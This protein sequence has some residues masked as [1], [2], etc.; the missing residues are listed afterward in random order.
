[1]KPRIVFLV[2]LFLSLFSPVY[3][4]VA[5]SDED[6]FA[7]HEET[8]RQKLNSSI[9][10]EIGLSCFD[11]HS[12]LRGI[13][14]FPHPEKLK[15]VSC[16]TC[17]SEIIK[18]WSKSIHGRAKS[19]GLGVVKCSDCHGDHDV[20]PKGDPQSL[21][22]PL[23]LPKTCE[24]CHLE[25][26]KTPRGSDFIRQYEG[27][28]HFR[29][30]EKAG[31][32]LSAN[33]SH[34]HGSHDILPTEDPDS[35]TSRR[36][37]IRTCGQCHVGIE[38]DY[39]EGVHGKDY[40]KGIK[41]VPVCTDCHQE[42]NILSP[43]DSRSS[44]YATKVAGVCSRCHDDQAIARQYGLLTGRYR[45][46]A[47]SY[48]G[49]ASRFGD[50]RVANCASCHGY[51]DIRPSSDPKSSIHPANIPQ[52]CGRCHPGASRR[53]AEGKVHLLPEQVET[54]KY[55]ISY[56]IKKI[57]IILIATIIS[58]FILFIAADLGRRL[59]RR[60]SHG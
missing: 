24:R 2:A 38:R 39:L 44:V 46:Y 59:W 7:C 3:P 21:V 14:E 8:F 17:H 29:A 50:I 56:I 5:Q 48:H 18:D 57:Y 27:S 33:C 34:C 22:Y 47:E 54:P 28:I 12:D 43:L 11:C 37:I 32:T 31:L 58:V 15:P 10:G 53:F 52:T 36:N 41:D 9:H 19:M 25:A 40:V 26:V 1:M 51:H 16:E 13:K 20:R 6:C 4:A 49:T 30:L 55:K 45:T 42:H 35:K 23:N 60:E